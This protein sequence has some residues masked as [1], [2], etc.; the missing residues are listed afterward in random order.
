MTV[1]MNQDC[2][3]S[4][5][6][7]SI[8]YNN[9][10]P[11]LNMDLTL[12]NA[13][14]LLG[15]DCL[16]RRSVSLSSFH[17][18]Y[19]SFHDTPSAMSHTFVYYLY[20]KSILHSLRKYVVVHVVEEI[21]RSEERR[22]TVIQRSH[23]KQANQDFHDVVL[24]VPIKRLYMLDTLCTTTLF[25]IHIVFSTCYKI[26]NQYFNELHEDMMESIFL[27]IPEISNESSLFIDLIIESKT[28]HFFN[29]F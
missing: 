3:I 18:S 23:G 16:L 14:D 24:F 6:Y 19:S 4:T 21:D 22:N 1:R 10:H 13:M 27:C 2:G 5:V 26:G 8:G 20:R 11:I 28:S 17:S 25:R 7:R 29:H 15:F 12:A 9:K